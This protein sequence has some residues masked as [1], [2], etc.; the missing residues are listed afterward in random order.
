MDIPP[1]T[2]TKMP[3]KLFK[4][5]EVCQCIIIVP[6]HPSMIMW[7]AP[8]II[9]I[10]QNISISNQNLML[11]QWWGIRRCYDIST[12]KK[13]HSRVSFHLHNII[14]ISSS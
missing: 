2:I 14:F 5:G 8:Y 13:R 10:D 4:R 1:V 6:S 12:L 9:E 7:T 11:F 3:E